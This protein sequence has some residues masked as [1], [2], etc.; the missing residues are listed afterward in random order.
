MTG[1]EPAALAAWRPRCVVDSFMRWIALCGG[2]PGGI[3]T[4]D[5]LVENQASLVARRRERDGGP[6]RHRTCNLRSK[7]P[8]L[9]RLSYR[10]VMASKAGLE[11]ATP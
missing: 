4:R 2:A 9:C 6:S 5:F 3:R 10:P 11:P 1:S 7:G 8:L